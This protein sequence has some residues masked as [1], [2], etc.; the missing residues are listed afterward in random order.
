MTSFAM[1][2]RRPDLLDDECAECGWS[3]WMGLCGCWVTA[4]EQASAPGDD[5]DPDGGGALA[6]LARALRELPA[7]MRAP[8]LIVAIARWRERKGY[9]PSIREIAAASDVS[10]TSV[11]VYRLRRLRELGAVDVEDGLTRTLRL[12]ATGEVLVARWMA[13]G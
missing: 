11:M 4:A 6:T 7:S 12:T 2:I 3:R 10:S 1:A 13:E 5:E 8:E 9:S